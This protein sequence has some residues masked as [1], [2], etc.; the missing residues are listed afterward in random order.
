[1]NDQASPSKL[2]FASD[3][4]EGAHPK[5]LQCLMETNL[6]HSA[7]YGTDEYSE[8][9]RALIRTACNA[10][11]AEIY[12]LVGGTKCGALIAKGYEISFACPTNQLFITVDGA[13]KERLEGAPG[14]EF[15]GKEA[16][17][18]NCAAHLHQLGYQSRGC[19][20]LNR[21]PIG[22]PYGT[23]GLPICTW[24]STTPFV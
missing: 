6:V 13:Q 21:N 24:W 2:F 9:A 19:R 23:W 1:M 4:M 18:T 14:T 3:Y 12:F 7:G 8:S 5:I 10:P 15:L 20:S 22:D 17:W 16:G 11:D